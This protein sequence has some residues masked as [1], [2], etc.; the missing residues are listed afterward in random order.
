VS[1]KKQSTDGV[2]APPKPGTKSV[3]DTSIRN[4]V[5]VEQV[6][7][8]ISEGVQA[9]AAHIALH[10]ID[11][12]SDNKKKQINQLF[13]AMD[14]V[15]PQLAALA[16]YQSEFTAAF[17]K[18]MTRDVEIQSLEAGAAYEEAMTTPMVATDN[19]ISTFLKDWAQ[20]EVDVVGQ[21]V[22]EGYRNGW[23]NDEIAQ[24]IRGTRAA[25]YSDGVV[26][27]IGRNAN[28][29]V[30]TVVQHVSQTAMTATWA[31]NADVIDKVRCVATLDGNTTPEC[32]SLDGQEFDLG[33]APQFPLHIGCRT[34]TVP[35]AKDEYAFLDEGATRSALDGPV[36]ASD[37]YYDWL[38]DQ[39]VAFQDD[40]L[41]ATR[42]QL[43]RNGGLSPEK[44]ARLNVG[45]NFKPLTLDQMRAKEPH[46][47]E[48]AGL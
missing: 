46:A 43:F 21:M 28:M 10:E 7:A 2:P 29:V 6:A 47:F 31:N 26:A 37:T 12:Y 45:R 27:R 34:V 18:K 32:R 24:A 38:S 16:D 25:E 8:G 39:P 14:D 4:K 48:K 13:A 35:V 40:V 3:I 5:Y 41:G 17:L 23:T 22:V 33:S 11:W 1:K 20:S 44:F 30:R 36:S 9:K 42:G 15:L 19:L